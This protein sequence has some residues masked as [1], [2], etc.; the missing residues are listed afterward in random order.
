MTTALPGGHRGA[1][2]QAGLARWPCVQAGHSQLHSDFLHELPQAS[3]ALTCLTYGNHR[4]CCTNVRG[5]FVSLKRAGGRA[6]IGPGGVLFLAGR[7]AHSVHME[8][9]GPAAI[10]TRPGGSRKAGLPRSLTGE[11]VTASAKAPPS[12]SI[13]CDA[14]RRFLSSSRCGWVT[15][16][17]ILGQRLK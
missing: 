8:T 14:W 12:G 2:G 17:A 4:I 11:L 9:R 1:M 16:P 5:L 15:G 7:T 13:L 10:N 3:F 6:C